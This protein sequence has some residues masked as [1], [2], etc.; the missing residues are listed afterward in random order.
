MFKSTDNGATWSEANS[1]LSCNA[2]H[3]LIVT[4]SDEIFAGTF[5]SGV[6]KSSDHGS[7][8]TQLNLGFDFVWSL[9]A[10]SD[11]LYAGTYGKGLYKSTDNGTTWSRCTGVTSSFIY[12]VAATA[13]GKNVF[14][15]AW[16]A[17]IF[18]LSSES[19]D[20]TSIGMTGYGSSAVFF[21]TA[22]KKVMVGT[23]SGAI[24][25]TDLNVTDVKSSITTKLTFELKQNYPN[26][27]NPSTS[28]NY[29]LDK[30]GMIS[31]AVYNITGQLVKT[32]VS[33]YQVKGN[34]SAQ[35]NAANMPSGIYFYRLTT[36]SQSMLKKMILL[37]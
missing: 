5:G 13:D 17:G 4:D 34:H 9:A 19:N 36:P 29:T 7:S 11:A 16:G 35:F 14:A 31:L 30:D 33:E 15:C 21:N 32:L 24:Y 26:P 1:G 22:S 6:V 23:G 2:I 12:D 27:F 10:S 20:F 37:K 28:I 25:T 8:W 18:A 3:S